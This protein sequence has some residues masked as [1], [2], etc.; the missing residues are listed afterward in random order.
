MGLLA[1]GNV[2]CNCCGNVH[3]HRSHKARQRLDRK[4]FQRCCYTRCADLCASVGGFVTLRSLGPFDVSKTTATGFGSQFGTVALASTIIVE[5]RDQYSNRVTANG[6]SPQAGEC[7][8][9]HGIAVFAGLAFAVEVSG[10]YTVTG[11][12]TEDA[13]AG[14]Y[15]ATYTATRVG[16]VGPS[17]VWHVML[18]HTPMRCSIPLPL[19]VEMRP[20]LDRPSRLRCD[21][22]PCRLQATRLPL[23]RV[24]RVASLVSL[25]SERSKCLLLSSALCLV[26]RFRQDAWFHDPGSRSVR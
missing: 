15:N 12:V 8:V 22:V 16:Q 20:F 25:T 5:P 13:A 24:S 21:L 7:V 3:C 18:C 11:E 9:V 2:E 6:G 10:S 4:F 14:T 23:A 26:H 19:P 1:L 17:L